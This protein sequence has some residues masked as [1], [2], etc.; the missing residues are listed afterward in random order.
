[1]PRRSV[2]ISGDV[3]TVAIDQLRSTQTL[4]VWV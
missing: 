3:L 2:K 1:L 4:F